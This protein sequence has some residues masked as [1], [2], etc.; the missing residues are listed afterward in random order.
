MKN[1]TS[2]MVYSFFMGVAVILLG[3]CIEPL[4]VVLGGGIAITGIVA[5]RIENRKRRYM[6]L[7]TEREK[8]QEKKVA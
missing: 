8:K 5:E 3:I 2:S 4:L 6:S 7:E 1:D